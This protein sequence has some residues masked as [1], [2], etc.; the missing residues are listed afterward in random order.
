MLEKHP[1]YST[2][3]EKQPLYSTILEKHPLYSTIL[4]KHPLY[5]TIAPLRLLLLKTKN[6]ELWARI[7]PL[8]DHNQV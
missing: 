1:Y 3:L 7:Q 4:E 2:I 6:P 5:S 8:M